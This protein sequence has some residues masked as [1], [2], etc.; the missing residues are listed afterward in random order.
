MELKNLIYEMLVE[1]FQNKKLLNQLFEK[2]K[3][4]NSNLTL[5]DMDFILTKFMGGR[6]DEGENIPA[7][8]DSLSLKRPEVRS[9]LNM[10]DGEYGNSR[11]DPKFLKQIQHYSYKQIKSL[12]LEFGVDLSQGSE[13]LDTPFWDKPGMGSDEKVAESKKLWQ[14]DRFKVYDDGKGFRI[15]H[16]KSQKD[17]IGFGFWQEKLKDLSRKSGNQ[18]CVTWE[19]TRNMWNTYRSRGLTFYFVIDETK[20][21][22]DEYYVSAIMPEEDRSI[23]YPFRISNLTNTIGE[24]PMKLDDENH[25]TCLKCIYPQLDDP[26]ALSV[27]QPEQYDSEKELNVNDDEASRVTEREGSPYQFK[28]V[29]RPLKLRY[30][31][32]GG[33][34]RKLE[35]FQSMD[36][37]V[38]RRY[39]DEINLN[40]VNDMFTFETLKYLTSNKD[41]KRKLIDRLSMVSAEAGDRGVSIATLFTNLIRT[42]FKPIHVSIAT[43]NIKIMEN[44]NTGKVGIFDASKGDWVNYSGISYEPEYEPV[45]DHLLFGSFDLDHVEDKEDNTDQ[46]SQSEPQP[47]EM[48]QEELQEQVED[49]ISYLIQ[50]Y[51]KSDNIDDDQN[52]YTLHNIA[53]EDYY[54]TIMSQKMWKQVGEPNFVDS[55]ETDDTKQYGDIR[56]VSQKP[57][58]E[59][60]DI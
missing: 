47:D 57:I 35:S 43:D 54:V 19:G 17:S 1:E 13:A 32:R 59:K 27:L 26:E 20:D 24:K 6:N 30:I 56:K 10:Y 21:S 12:F 14:G 23:R 53:R 48:G 45:L 11:F 40:N 8:K 42:E 36:N 22:K 34:L 39:I 5:E 18:W 58:N 50:A 28:R 7:L 44:T 9:F 33:V 31:E 52:F 60:G 29:S 4:E 25:D 3:S 46:E 49:Q 41:L 38:S 16:P 15:Y 55:S 2:W 37:V 51:S